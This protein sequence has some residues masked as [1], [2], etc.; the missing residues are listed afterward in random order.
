MPVLTAQG[1]SARQ[2]CLK[3]GNS[4]CNLLKI[5]RPCYTLPVSAQQ[6]SSPSSCLATAA[7]TCLLPLAPMG[8]PA[9]S[10]SILFLGRGKGWAYSS[11][12]VL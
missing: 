2:S 8:C 12:A 1:A 7:C 11:S 9:A 3:Y 4:S 5:G 6:C 10:E